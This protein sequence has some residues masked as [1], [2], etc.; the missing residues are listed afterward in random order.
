MRRLIGLV[1]AAVTL[2]FAACG[3]GAGPQDTGSA[4]DNTGSPASRSQ[5][6][7][8]DLLAGTWQ[9]TI[10]PS[11]LVDAPDD[12][13][14]ERSV[15]R[16]KFLGTGGEDNGPSLFLSNEQI[17]EIAHSISLS[18]DEITL[19]SDTGCKRF[20]YVEIDMETVQIRSTEQDRGCPSTLISSVLQ[21]PW[22]L[23]ERGPPRREPTTAEGSL[24]SR[25]AFVDCARQRDELGVVLGFRDG[26]AVPEPGQDTGSA[27][28][29]RRVSA[30]QAI[31]DVLAD[32]GQYVGLRDGAGPDVD[33][34]FHGHPP[35]GEREVYNPLTRAMDETVEKGIVSS[36]LGDYSALAGT[37]EWLIVRPKGYPPGWDDD[38]VAFRVPRALKHLVPCFRQAVRA[39]DRLV[40][41]PGPLAGVWRTD[42]ITVD[43][44]SR[45]LRDHGLARWIGRFAKTSPIGRTP[46]ALVLEIDTRDYLYPRDWHLFAEPEAGSRKA[47]IDYRAQAETAG[48]RGLQH[49]ED[50]DQLVVSH[51]GDTNTYRWS[52]DGGYLT[53][54]WQKTTYP[55][56]G[57][58]PEEVFQ[59]ALYMTARFKRVG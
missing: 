45:T 5:N 42:P 2:A 25:E 30:A 17:G 38:L 3:G 35:G 55:P 12:L 51:E 27:D 57:G 26:R 50:G 41:A 15:W 52:V 44:M 49:E 54:T 59:R 37:Q 14:E 29:D 9:A 10:E 18:G 13:T 16:L 34:I 31:A 56:H 23:V 24:A 7:I 47:L 11:R 8:P 6:G 58:I 20:A 1:A 40:P 32:G 53:L 21:R 33:I 48:G 39:A 4:R 22:R 19:Q 36:N 43:D 46:T 28:V